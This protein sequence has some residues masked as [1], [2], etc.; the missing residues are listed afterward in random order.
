MA[1]ARSGRAADRR[2]SGCCP[3]R[4]RWA[5][6]RAPQSEG[7]CCAADIGAPGRA[8]G[9]SR[10]RS[11]RARPAAERA[12]A[13]AAGTLSFVG[14]RANR[15]RAHLDRLDTCCLLGLDFELDLGWFLFLFSFWASSAL[16]AVRSN[17]PKFGQFRF[18]EG[19]KWNRT[20]PATSEWRERRNEFACWPNFVASSEQRKR[21]PS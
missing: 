2:P 8:A 21:R 14:G 11:G 6:P 16:S 17:L 4:C 12:R 19:C 15:A 13:A 1:L 20:E 10:A 7:C 18:G 5:R 9:P 3:G